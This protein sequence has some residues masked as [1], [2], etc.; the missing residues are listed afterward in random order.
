MSGLALTPGSESELRRLSLQDAAC[1]EV[2]FPLT[3]LWLGNV[4]RPRPDVRSEEQARPVQ[5]LPVVPPGR[6]V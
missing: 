1:R 5:L 6:G 2:S 3:A 4:L